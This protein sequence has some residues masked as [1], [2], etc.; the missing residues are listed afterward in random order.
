MRQSR[1]RAYCCTGFVPSSITN[2]GNLVLYGQTSVLSKRGGS[3]TGLSIYVRDHGL[4]ERGLPGLILSG[5]GL[6]SLCLADL[7]PSLLGALPTFGLSLIGEGVVCALGALAGAAATIYVGWQIISGIVGWL[8]GGSPSKPNVGVP[9]KVGTRTA[10]GQW[11]I[12]DFNG[13]ATTTSCDCEVTYTCRYGLGWDEICDNQR[14]AINKLL[15]GKT[16]Y[17]PLT[18]QNGR[19]YS[20]WRSSQRIGAYRTRA[21]ASI[22]NVARCQ[23]DEFPM[24]N[25]KESGNNS[26]QACR[27]VNGPANGRQGN[28]YKAWKDAQ[29]RPCSAYRSTKCG[30][31]DDGP[32]A[33]WAFGPL[34]A[35]RGSGSGQHFID[36]YGFD[37]QTVNSLC[38]ATY[39][40]TDQPGVISTSTVTDH[41]FRVLDDDPTC[42]LRS[43]TTPLASATLTSN[44]LEMANDAYLDLD[45]DNLYFV[46]LDGNPIDG[47]TCNII[48]EDDGPRSEVRLVLDEDGHVVD[49]YMGDPDAGSW[50]KEEVKSYNSDKV[51]VDATTVTVTTGVLAGSE[52]RP[53]FAASTT[54]SETRSEPY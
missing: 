38:W 43:I 30:I 34:P 39:T 16:V 31:N 46:D 15:N 22:N 1:R 19:K 36:A 50:T 9:T 48:Y 17:Q 20:S 4:E 21:Q 13:G 14:W 54:G 28:D 32:P 51:T 41:G 35:G 2:S 49:M 40:Y 7:V 12:L 3:N 5:L 52:S 44:S 11:S 24:G 25:L 23:L 47:R 10:Y 8:F 27:L 29:W 33:T 37:E 53:T 6:G 45:Y 18:A 26:P 42:R